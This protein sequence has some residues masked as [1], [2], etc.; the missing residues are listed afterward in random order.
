[1]ASMKLIVLSLLVF[2]LVGTAQTQQEEQLVKASPIESP[3]DKK[4]DSRLL[5]EKK[6]EEMVRE[7]IED[8]RDRAERK[9][10][11][12]IIDQLNGKNDDSS[13]GQGVH[14]PTV[15]PTPIIVPPPVEANNRKE[16]EIAQVQSI[17]GIG[18]S[19]Y[20]D[21]AN[22]KGTYSIS[23]DLGISFPSEDTVY[24]GQLSGSQF[25]FSIGGMFSSY[26]MEK[27]PGITGAPVGTVY[28]V[29][30]PRV[31][32][33]RETSGSVGLKYYLLNG[34]VRPSVGALGIYT[35][36]TYKDDSIFLDQFDGDT[37]H[38]FDMG[39]TTGVDI[40]LAKAITVGAEL[41]YIFNLSYRTN[42]D[43]RSV[44]YSDYSPFG[45]RPIESID[46]YSFLI[47]MAFMF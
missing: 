11:K 28:T 35:H 2:P 24:L 1:M 36:R 3:V 29:A 19:N 22:V 42:D 15:V 45:A 17:V 31:F 44:V 16:Q 47:R 46:R 41:R 30:Y 5:E 6:T 23:L 4:R 18:V 39:L 40:A 25:V 10:R 34:R 37:S 26:D 9:R 43:F 14:T 27:I 21:T 13:T 33:L 20:V 32:E 12:K 8:D 7:K 38:A